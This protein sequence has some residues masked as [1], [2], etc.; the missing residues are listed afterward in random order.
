MQDTYMKMIQS[1]NSYNSKY[2]FKT[3][4]MTIARNKAIDSYRKRRQ[5]TL[6]DIQASEYLLPQTK[7]G[8]DDE[9]NANF[10]LSLLDDEEREIVVLYAIDDFKH[11]E[12]AE[13]TG[14]PIGTVTWI[15]N[16]AVKK[17]R[18]EG[19]GIKIWKKKQF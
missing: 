12:I 2:K 15:Y 3:W 7:S 10:L 13:I 6:I 1:I 4:L 18:A 5:E 19:E 9:Y 14:K 8:V 11:K 17:M 16:K